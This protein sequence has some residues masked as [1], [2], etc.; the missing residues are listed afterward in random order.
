M[1]LWFDTLST[2]TIFT[3][4][5]PKKTYH[6]SI[7][8]EVKNDFPFLQ[9][10]SSKHLIQIPFKFS[11]VCADLC[12]GIVVTPLALFQ[13]VFY[14]PLPGLCWLWVSFDV[15]CCTASCLSLMSRIHIV[16]FLHIPNF[17]RYRKID[18]AV[19]FQFLLNDSIINVTK[20]YFY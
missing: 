5:R 11:N 3:N 13:D 17:F 12:I 16:L 2:A 9:L 10:Y 7:S 4:F 15:M 18:C 19:K 1:L 14:W 8:S 6:T 20:V